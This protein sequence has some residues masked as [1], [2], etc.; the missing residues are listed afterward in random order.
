LQL[1]GE[2]TLSTDI[3]I[4]VFSHASR[5]GVN[6]LEPAI[7][8]L[9]LIVKVVLACAA[10]GVPCS[11][12]FGISHAFGPT[13]VRASCQEQVTTIAVQ[14][15]CKVVGSSTDVEI[16][17]LAVPTRGTSTFLFRNLH[18]TLLASASDFILIT[19]AFLH[20]E[21]GKE[22][23]GK[24]ML[25]CIFLEEM[26][27]FGTGFEGSFIGLKGYRERHKN[28]VGCSNARGLPA[29]AIYSTIKEINTSV[30]SGS[31]RRLLR[32]STGTAV[33]LDVENTTGIA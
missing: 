20:G 11:R 9:V 25:V 33:R 30:G 29:A 28:D 24:A 10:R 31:L 15:G 1:N 7:E 21:G 8:E 22:D 5:T 27:I 2:E 32:S 12:S 23:R 6:V 4:M 14:G 3:E 13:V 16:R 17:F 26:K 19:R 18:K